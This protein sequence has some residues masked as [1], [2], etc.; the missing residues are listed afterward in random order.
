MAR[1]KTAYA[2]KDGAKY[3]VS[4]APRAAGAAVAVYDNPT[5]VLQ[6]AVGRGMILKWD[7]PDEIDAAQ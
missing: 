5:A 2:W 6:A 3:C 1:L 4:T 7:N